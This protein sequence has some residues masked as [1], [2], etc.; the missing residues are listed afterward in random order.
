LDGFPP[1]AVADWQAA[2]RELLGDKP[3]EQ[4]LYTPTHEGFALSPIYTAE[5]T[6]GLPHL[7]SFPGFGRRLR[8]NQPEGALT[9]A[10]TVSQ[11]LAEPTPAR[12]AAA[13][14]EACAGGQNE[15]NIILA[16]AAARGLDPD[17]A[18]VQ[19]M[20]GTGGMALV[21][22]ADLAPLLAAAP[23]DR[24]GYFWQAGDAPGAV[25]A[26][27]AAAAR[28][29]G[30]AP[31]RLRGAVACDPFGRLAASGT[32][33][34]GLASACAEMAALTR[35][36][37]AHA[38]GLQT[39]TPAGHVYHAGG[40]AAHQEMA[41]VLAAGVASLRELAARGIAPAAAAPH[42]R[43]CLSIGPHF[44]IEVARFRAMRLLWAR[45][46]EALEVPAAARMA[47]L[48][49]RTGIWNKTVLDPHVNLLRT[50]V[51]AF[52]AV[53]GGCDSLHV[54]AFDELIRSGDPQSRRIA[55]NTH[56]ILAEECSLARVIDP[57]GGSWAV[58]ALT[59]R[60]ASQAWRFFQE[61]E[62]AGGILGALQA[63]KIQQWIATVRQDKAKDIQRR[64]AVLIGINQ[65]PLSREPVLPSVP[66][67]TAAL[68]AERLA[69]LAAHRATVD[70]A[71]VATAL[72]AVRAAPAG[73][74]DVLAAAVAAAAAGATLGQLQQALRPAAA[75]PEP[76]VATIAVHRAAA[77]FEALRQR[78]AAITTATGAPP[79]I[80]QL[81]IGPSRR[82]RLRA[83]WTTGFFQTGGFAVDADTDFAD[84]A[85]ATAAAAAH[86]ARI[87]VITADDETCAA[88]AAD[89]ARALKA[90]RPDLHLLLAGNPG[91]HEADWRA[92]G[93]DDFVNVRVNCFAVNER[94][95]AMLAG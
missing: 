20:P 39:I 63:G 60:L 69:A 84:A 13:L 93:I 46:L 89:L 70:A 2:A 16:A 72:A 51:E 66:V 1:H 95:L 75:T 33:T 86:P 91:A 53:V 47:H 77:D 4:A 49:A 74:A 24:I 38:P 35:Y 68:H 22:A 55:R 6:A 94:L 36:A 11:E 58:E 56:A 3:L 78:A 59:D 92:A 42:V 81:N 82:Y 31:A 10:W 83:D 18:G 37:I 64:R 34:G 17:A 32:L 29:C 12:L 88:G 85:A 65:Y 27:F 14:A 90:A 15:A 76:A 61:I 44:F 87:A 7:E 80:L 73:S 41:C 19:E 52:A 54:G 79:R 67:D 50:T 30:V 43:L 28:A 45:V 25:L 57:A 9:A 71:A 62:A 8:G 40:A 5:D 21:A 23:A 48:H 26:L